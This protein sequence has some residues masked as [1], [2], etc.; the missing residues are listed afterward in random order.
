M[1]GE[2]AHLWDTISSPQEY[3]EE[4]KHWRNVLR[5]RLGPGRH[6]ILE[7]GVGGGHN[8]HHFANEFQTTAIDISERM[9]ANSI[10]LNPG[11][12]HLVGD[13]RTLRLGRTFKAVLVHDAINYMLTRDDLRAA[14]ATARAH[15]DTGGVFIAAP[16]WFK[17]TF[18]GTHMVYAIRKHVTPEL[19]FIEHVSDPDPSDE[20]LEWVFFYL[21][22]EGGRV[23]VEEDH[24]VVGIYS[25]DTWAQLLREEGFSMETVQ[26]PVHDTGQMVDLVV[27]T[28]L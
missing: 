27:G 1:Y 22:S 20:R 15:L 13:M 26:Y 8:L 25:R 16:D 11:V 10:R 17:E 24:H 18:P 4:S 19:T 23:R 2:F 28:A 7:L 21:F 14:I 3:A 5:A 9:L 12:E 6:P